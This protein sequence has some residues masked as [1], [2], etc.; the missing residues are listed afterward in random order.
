MKVFLISHIAD[1]DGV[2]P[3][4]LTDLAF[5]NYDYK[6]L[7]I[8]D[9]DTFMN[10]SLDNNLFDEYDKVFMTDLNISDELA[11]RIN[12]SDFK[13]KFQVLD[14]HIGAIELNKYDF[15][16]V[17]DEANGMKESGTSLYYKYLLTYYP[18]DLLNKNSVKYMVNLV[19]LGDT[20]EWKKYNILEA[21]DLSTILY[22][23]GNEEFIDNYKMF[24]RENNE[25]YFNKMENTLLKI[26]KYK[27]EDYIN[28][29]KDNMV[30]RDINGYKVGIV[31][32]ENYR[33]E[34]GN[35][36]S[37]IYKDK[38][39]FVMIINLNRSISFRCIK[40]NV[41]VN[42]IANL[43][44][45]GGHKKAAGAPLKEGTYEKLI[46]EFLKINKE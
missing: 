4:I 6:L 41:D 23:Y 19:R 2:M 14:H 10:E 40:D 34:L 38:I 22:Y 1:A 21:R 26:D 28:F 25:F 9:V 15:E 43:F 37:E 3:V 44:N 8:K 12:N 36:L 13:E 5:E 46:D 16:K 31:F 20:W 33:S 18:N 30:I 35:E 29:I 11:Q 42:E 39:D 45:G 7:D 24:L 32:A 27:K 17:V